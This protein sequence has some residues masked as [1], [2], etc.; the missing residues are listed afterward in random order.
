MSSPTTRLAYG[1]CFE[2]FDQAYN[3]TKGIRFQ[4]QAESTAISLRLRMHQARSIDRNDNRKLYQPGEPLYG[5]SIYD[6]LQIRYRND[7]D[8]WWV[9]IEPRAVPIIGEIETLDE[10]EDIAWLQNSPP[11]LISH[12]GGELLEKKSDSGSNVLTDD[13][14]SKPSTTPESKLEIQNLRR[15]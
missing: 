8:A 4:V 11:K 15:L 10:Q 2:L 14:S 3:T 5:C 9:Y 7:G 12:S 1:D 13:S 6:S